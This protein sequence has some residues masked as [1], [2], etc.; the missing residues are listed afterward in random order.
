MKATVGIGYETLCLEAAKRGAHG[1]GR[2]P[3]CLR[4]LLRGEVVPPRS[5]EGIKVG[6][7]VGEPIHCLQNVIVCVALRKHWIGRAS[8][9]PVSGVPI[10]A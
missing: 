1:W 4:C 6:C 7:S 10:L 8:C 5:R 3:K 9:R 2:A